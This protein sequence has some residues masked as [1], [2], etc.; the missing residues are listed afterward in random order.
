MVSDCCLLIQELNRFLNI[1][2]SNKRIVTKCV[3]QI[4]RVVKHISNLGE[5]F[6]QINSKYII[7][8]SMYYV[9]CKYISVTALEN[10]IMTAKSILG[11]HVAQVLA[12]ITTDVLPSVLAGLS[13]N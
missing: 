3:N 8:I 5:N 7:C 1:Q 13:N 6:L 11:F 9:L 12:C 10:K 4:K 2:A